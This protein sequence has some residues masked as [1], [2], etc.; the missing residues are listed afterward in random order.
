MTILDKII[1]GS[2]NSSKSDGYSTKA[3]EAAVK[4]LNKIADSIIVIEY[5]QKLMDS[6]KVEHNRD[7]TLKVST[8]AGWYSEN[9]VLNILYSNE[10]GQAIYAWIGDE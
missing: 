7:Y 10:S 5:L 2:Q 6:P 3:R 4:D 9:A 8:P 1:K